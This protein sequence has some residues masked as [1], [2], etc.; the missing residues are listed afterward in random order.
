M[1]DFS[2][3]WPVWLHRHILH[4]GDLTFLKK[5]L[6][7][8][9]NLLYYYDQLAGGHDAPLGDLHEYLGT[10]CFLDHG[11]IDRE[12]I[13]T[14]LNALYCRALLSAWLATCRGDGAGHAIQE[15]RFPCGGATG[16]CADEQEGLYAD[17]IMGAK[18]PFFPA[19]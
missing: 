3:N 7:T 18:S 13:V 17:T 5:M 12:G 10:Y 16:L 9:Q 2:L 4:T 8:L 19:D 6:P 14:G 1:P 11:P 15:P